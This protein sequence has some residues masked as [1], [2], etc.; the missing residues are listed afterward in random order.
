MIKRLA[1]CIREYKWAAIL[2]PLC[3][4]GEVAMEVMIPLVMAELYDHGITSV[5]S[6][7]NGPMALD[8]AMNRGAELLEQTAE[9]VTRT[10][11]SCKKER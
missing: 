5:H 1:R 4:V 11:I 10:Y 2:S 7:I 3:M 6:I 8:V 9:Q